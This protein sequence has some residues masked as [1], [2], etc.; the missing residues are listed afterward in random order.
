MGPSYEREPVVGKWALI[1]WFAKSANL[2]CATVNAR[3][4]ELTD[5]ASYSCPGA[6]CPA[7]HHPG[8]VIR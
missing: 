4:E 5:K 8:E 7:S 2:P 6:A 3:S 1:P